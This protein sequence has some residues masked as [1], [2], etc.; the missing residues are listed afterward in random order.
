MNVAARTAAGLALVV[1]LAL[2]LWC[3]AG[4][5]ETGT[6]AP[7]SARVGSTGAGTAPVTRSRE[8][9]AE[10]Q[11][12]SSEAASSTQRRK[13]AEAQ[14][15]SSDSNSSTQDD[16]DAETRRRS[17]VSGSSTQR[18]KDAEAQRASSESGGSEGAGKPLATIE[19]RV[20]DAQGN[21]V[22][23]LSVFV[24]PVEEG[25]G[26]QQSSAGSTTDSRGAFRL[27]V[28]PGPWRLVLQA[29]SGAQDVTLDAVA[30]EIARVNF[31]PLPVALWTVGILGVD[32]QEN[33]PGP[34]VTLRVGEAVISVRQSR[35]NQPLRIAPATNSPLR[36]GASATITV[37]PGSRRYR[38]IEAEL[39]LPPAGEQ[40]KVQLT[41]APIL[42]LTLLLGAEETRADLSLGTLP[43]GQLLDQ[44][45]AVLDDGWNVETSARLW[46]TGVWKEVGG[47]REATLYLGVDLDL[48]AVVRLEVTPR[49]P[50]YAGA[51][52]EHT[53]PRLLDVSL[54][55]STTRATLDLR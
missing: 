41:P 22:G 25:A 10:T 6:A 20:L 52:I 18:R 49:R 9:N 43:E 34:M 14:R 27:S 21:G 23:G 42:E 47:Q 32:D 40:I 54:T 11:R 31:E 36:P 5:D 13:D 37:Q 50:R 8:G 24:R 38:S 17:S 7:V 29:Q 53:E 3:V 35:P 55:T 51:P 48:P 1:A 30:G 28:D 33:V 44:R 15:A 19:G 45:S 39:V 26:P 12:S 2:G 46:S 16:K 4:T